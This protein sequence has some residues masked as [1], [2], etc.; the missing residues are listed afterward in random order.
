[1]AGDLPGDSRCCSLSQ[2][3]VGYRSSIGF[4]DQKRKSSSISI[5]SDDAII[6]RAD[7]SFVSW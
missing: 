5:Q 6:E 3:Q 4:V 2:G 7:A 1:M